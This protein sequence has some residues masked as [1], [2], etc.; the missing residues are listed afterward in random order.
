MIQHY[1]DHGQC[2]PEWL[3]AARGAE[4]DDAV[5]RFKRQVR[6]DQ[7]GVFHDYAATRR[8]SQTVAD[9]KRLRAVVDAPAQQPIH[10]DQ[11]HAAGWFLAGV[12]TATVI[13]ALCLWW[14]PV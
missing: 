11:G 4:A 6:Q 1:D 3:R 7:A 2:T 12:G 13:F 10:H 14:A 9:R 5:D 8:M